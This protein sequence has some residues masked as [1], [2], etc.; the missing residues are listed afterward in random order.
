MREKEHPVRSVAPPQPPACRE[1]FIVV[2]A[3]TMNSSHTDSNVTAM[4]VAAHEHAAD[5]T[6]QR[7]EGKS[8]SSADRGTRKGACEDGAATGS[9]KCAD[10]HA[11]PLCSTGVH[12]GRARGPVCWFSCCE[13]R[14]KGPLCTRRGRQRL[15]KTHTRA[16]VVVCSGALPRS[17][18]VSVLSAVLWCD[19]R[20]VLRLRASKTEETALTAHAWS[21]AS[22]RGTGM[23]TTRIDS[24]SRSERIA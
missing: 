8:S 19:S 23:P 4:F 5:W 24:S 6:D 16:G 7:R 10:R 15:D 9:C 13:R 21:D 14:A 2:C 1:L 22:S 17:S 18:R 20:R 12:R 3:R 11:P